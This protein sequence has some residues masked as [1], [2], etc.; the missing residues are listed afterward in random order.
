MLDFDEALNRVL[1]TMQRMKEETIGMQNLHNRVLAE[2]VKAGMDL[3]IADNASVDGYAV[4][5]EDLKNA[6]PKKPVQLAILGTIPAGENAPIKVTKGNCVRLFT[7]SFLPKG[8]DAILMQEDT[9]AMP[10]QS[11]VLCF[12]AVKPFENIR[13]KGEDVKSKTKLIE[14]GTRLRARHLGLLAALGLSSLK[15]FK[16]PKVGIL[17]TG[18]ELQ[19]AGKPLRAGAIYESNRLILRELVRQA[20]G[21]SELYPL[22]ED[23]MEA[24]LLA[25]KAA[26]E[27]DVILSSGGVSVGD[28]D[29]IRPAI[30]AIGGVIDFWGVRL[31]PG[32][33]FVL[34]QIGGK[35]LFGLAGNPVSAITT[36]ML[37]VRPA[38]LKM[39]GATDLKPRMRRGILNQS[40]VNREDRP[41]YL[42]VRFDEKEGINTTGLQGSHALQSLCRADG[43][44][45]VAPNSTLK[46]GEP[47]SVMLWDD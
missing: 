18:G 20:G 11:S 30:E 10:E 24:S 13:F 17:A 21:E 19:E 25:L 4:R 35:P 32:K 9:K 36:F 31:R 12:S 46:K 33:P 8:A 14:A 38:L 29:F 47:V 41:H 2:E 45:C 5:A 28:Y 39:Q 3:P 34:A 22:V 42:R 44:L 26:S 1:Q 15:V 40:I 6:S 27:N 16:R 7:G 23:T 37:L 43:W